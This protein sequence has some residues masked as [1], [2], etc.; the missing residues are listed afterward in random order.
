VHELDRPDTRFDALAASAPD[1]ILTID[2]DS[3]ILSANPATE[4]IFGW[5]PGELLGRSMAVLIPE[6]LRAAHHAGI[7]RYLASGRR[8]IPW[9][10]V[11]L[12]GLTKDGREIP[13]EISFGEFVDEGGRHVFSG[14]VRDVSERVRHR[15]E[16]ARIG[17]IT[18]VALARGTYDEM[19]RELLHRLREELGADAA[20][21]LLLDQASRE[22]VVR[23]WDG[24]DAETQAY[25]RVPLGRGIAGRVAATGEPV[26]IDDVSRVDVVSPMLRQHVT[27][28]AAVPVRSEGQIIGALHVGS[29][30]ARH[31]TDG[32]VRLLA[33]VAE[34][35][36]GVLSRTRMYEAERGAREEAERA[37]RALAEREAE[38]RRV[39]A[40][41]AERA[42]EE[43]ALRTLA[44]SI[45]GAV[46]V[47]EVMHQIAEGALAVSAASGAFVE[48]VV[49]ADGAVEVVASAG[50]RTPPLGQR[51]AYPGSLTEEIIERN[52]PVFLARM[53]G[54]GAAMAPYLD[55]HCHGCSVLVVPLLADGRAP[56]ARPPAARVL[57][58]LVL[59]RDAGE[60]PF[61]PGIVGRVRTLGDL[62]SLSLQRL[63][64][65]SESERRRAEAEAAVRSRDEV[66]SVVSHDLRNP[67]ST[68]AMSASLLQDPEVRLTDAERVTQ[69][70]VIVRSAQ[71][72][73]RLIQDLLDVARIE[74]GRLTIQ[75]RCED[76]AALAAEAAEA[77]RPIAAEKSLA[78][79]YD[80]AP[81]LRAVHA[82]RDRVLQV[83]S[84]YLN[85]A[86]K[87]TPAGGR[88]GLRVA[89]TDAGGVRFAVSD[90]GPGI[91]EADLPNVFERHWQARTTAH[92]G[93]GLGLAI[94]RGIA[95]AHR[96]RAY[97]ESEVGAGS[98]FVLELPPSRDCG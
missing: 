31:F 43:R 64:A 20:T 94:A 71:R 58:A 42:R 33:I 39:N 34:R 76:P 21:V 52:E 60:P 25:G 62:T 47:S 69:L 90:T 19:L 7:A 4:R 83:L 89:P 56:G 65:L 50:E 67:V 78:L 68:V 74:G 5:S 3:T 73:N 88:V 13:L 15:E 87:F 92:L 48:Q 10:G 63:V 54:L 29:R 98:T 95:Q 51:V 57:G 45:T 8:N 72:M 55:R 26:V 41:L 46:R 23:A 1:A 96:G 16:L 24:L 22:L 49:D 6:R 37:R 28:V 79:D 77:F 81:G 66:L 38:L 53:E 70:D 30:A 59:L 40:E 27:S 17:R 84:N 14:F 86:V 2:A 93:T 9:T 82:D 85:N 11:E 91:A 80:A 36:A 44:Q 18:D 35:M 61:E 75:C 12:P 32:D 97:A